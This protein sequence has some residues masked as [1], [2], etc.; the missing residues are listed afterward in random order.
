L[1]TYY[2][3]KEDLY[4]A[5]VDDLIER[6][7]AA[8]EMPLEPDLPVT[9]ALRLFGHGMMGIVLSE[10][11]V[12][13]HRLVIGEAGRFPELGRLFYERGP[14]RGKAKL[15]AYLGVAMADGRVRSGDP[16]Q[17]ATQ[18]AFLCQSGHHQPHLLGVIPGPTPADISAD[19]ESA[20][21]TFM[22]GWQST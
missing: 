21:N 3:S 16:W 10:P 4:V 2:P 9:D 22:T 11:I 12:A 14:A 8:L 17:A 7:G 13:L 19:I 1:W 6:F 20:I 5:V 15:A 18:F